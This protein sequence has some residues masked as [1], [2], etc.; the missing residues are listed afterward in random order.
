MNAS[1]RLMI[2]IE[3]KRMSKIDRKACAVACY[4]KLKEF[5]LSY[6]NDFG[7]IGFGEDEAFNFAYELWNLIDS[8]KAEA[9]PVACANASGPNSAPRVKELEW[10]RDTM[11]N[12]YAHSSIGQYMATDSG[13]YLNGRPIGL[14]KVEP[15]AACQEDYARRILSALEEE[16]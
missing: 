2:G 15:K 11:G 3:E 10:E 4:K 12:W 5:V 14:G 16:L 7:V 13:A 1:K 6:E 9:L 8:S